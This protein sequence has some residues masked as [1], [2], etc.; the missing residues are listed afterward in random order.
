MLLGPCALVHANAAT[1]QKA[2]S[3]VHVLIKQE[4]TFMTWANSIQAVCRDSE[5]DQWK[6]F[7]ILAPPVTIQT[8]V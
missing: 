7:K 3:S 6:H 8:R 4:L 2:G 5:D 1:T